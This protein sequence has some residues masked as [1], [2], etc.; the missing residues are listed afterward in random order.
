MGK[1]VYTLSTER[2]PD[3]T[4]NSDGAEEARRM[5]LAQERKRKLYP[6]RINAQ[7]VIYVPIERCN[8]EYAEQYREKMRY[9]AINAPI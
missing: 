1:K 2:K 7:T 8:E 4:R 6:L 3:V 9:N 5:R